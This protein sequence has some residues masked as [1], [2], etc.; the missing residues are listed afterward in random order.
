MH[1]LGDPEPSVFWLHDGKEISESEDF[2]FRRSGNECQ[3]CI[4]DVFPEDSG[5]YIFVAWNHKGIVRTEAKLK[6]Q[7]NT[8][9]CKLLK[10][11]KH[12]YMNKVLLYCA[13]DVELVCFVSSTSHQFPVT[14]TEVSQKIKVEFYAKDQ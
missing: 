11:A 13:T 1:L 7:G 8:Y 9:L 2:N 3:L 14:Y 6:V 4:W 12:E 10:I 5:K